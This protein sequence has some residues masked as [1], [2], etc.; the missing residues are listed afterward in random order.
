VIHHPQI[1]A[2]GIVVENPHPEAGPLR[3]TR[4]APQFS[5]TPTEYRLPA[6]A[7]GEHS[8][9]VLTEFGMAVDEIEALVAAGVVTLGANNTGAA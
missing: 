5:N 9:E 1:V 3:Q 4:P 6:P 2:N 8:A 7:L